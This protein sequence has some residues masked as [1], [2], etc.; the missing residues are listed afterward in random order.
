MKTDTI[1][2]VVVI[3]I[4]LTGTLGIFAGIGKDVVNNFTEYNNCKQMQK[5]CPAYK[6]SPLGKND[7]YYACI[8]FGDTNKNKQ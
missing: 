2:L 1:L 5:L 6:C 4:L 3:L 7:Y 8:N